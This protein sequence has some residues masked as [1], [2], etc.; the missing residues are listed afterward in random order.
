M[1]SGAGATN[2][3]KCERPNDE[4]LDAQLFKKN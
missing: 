1:H 4:A 3:V 2:W